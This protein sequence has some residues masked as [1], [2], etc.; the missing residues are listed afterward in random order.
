[1]EESAAVGERDELGERVWAFGPAEERGVAHLLFYTGAVRRWPGGEEH[2]G[3][4]CSECGR[5]NG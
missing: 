2:D 4:I 1:M 3:D 5:R